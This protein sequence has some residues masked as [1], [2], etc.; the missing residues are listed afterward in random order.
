[1]SAANCCPKPGY[2]ATSKRDGKSGSYTG[3]VNARGEAHEPCLG[4]SHALDHWARCHESDQAHSVLHRL[5]GTTAELSGYAAGEVES[6]LLLDSKRW[7]R[8]SGCTAKTMIQKSGC[9]KSSKT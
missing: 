2:G 5:S 4:G 9:Q 7:R 6:A 8:I 1:M 3:E